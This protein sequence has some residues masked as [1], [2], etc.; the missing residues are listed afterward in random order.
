MIGRVFKAVEK[1]RNP[2]NVI[3]VHTGNRRACLIVRGSNLRSA[4]TPR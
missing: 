2:S 3:M 1:P 4:K